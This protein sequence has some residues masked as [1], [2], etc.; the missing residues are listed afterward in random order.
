MNSAN[1]SSTPTATSIALASSGCPFSMKDVANVVLAEFKKLWLELL[2]LQ[3]CNFLTTM[4][5]SV[6]R[7]FF[8]EVQKFFCLGLP[9]MVGIT[10]ID[11][12]NN[13]IKDPF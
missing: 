2:K 4:R 3:G 12:L 8:G 7:L 5:L 1:N 6:L 10:I 11:L 9:I 13:D